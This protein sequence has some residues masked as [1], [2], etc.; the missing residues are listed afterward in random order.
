MI[1]YLYTS[2]Y[3]GFYEELKFFCKTWIRLG[4]PYNFMTPNGTGEMAYMFSN[5]ISQRIEIFAPFM[6]ITHTPIKP[7]IAMNSYAL[8]FHNK[9]TVIVKMELI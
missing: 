1:K 2:F 3:H 9:Y 5:F 4:I 8:I 7:V 6:Y